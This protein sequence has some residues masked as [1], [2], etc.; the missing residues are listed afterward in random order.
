[1]RN[2]VT[3]IAFTAAVILGTWAHSLR[4]EN[5]ELGRRINELQSEL[6]AQKSAYDKLFAADQKERNLV[7]EVVHEKIS[8]EQTALNAARAKLMELQQSLKSLQA[9]AKPT[10]G[11]IALDETLDAHIRD[12]QAGISSLTKQLAALGDD[13]QTVNQR[14]RA[15]RSQQNLAFS[16]Q[17]ATIELKRNQ[18]ELMIRDTQNQI[19]VLRQ[20][21]NRQDPDRP[22]KL[23]Q[24]NSQLAALQ[25]QKEQA[26]QQLN[27]INKSSQIKSVAISQE[28]Q[29]EQDEI[30]TDR[31][32][33]TAQLS[34]LKKDLEIWQ[35]KKKQQ[36]DQVASQRAQVQAQQRLQNDRMQQISQAIAEQ[37]ARVNALEQTVLANKSSH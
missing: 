18:I 4:S 6:T 31:A 34:D 26:N 16:E 37:T 5:H 10:G 17:R 33:V 11:D 29:G 25:L 8:T 36:N 7:Q 9:G 30:K 3:F 27:G 32:T 23:Q 14:S 20:S 21:P 24:L 22:A 35:Q 28:V 15:F 1:M 19:Q 13:T 2:G 12:D